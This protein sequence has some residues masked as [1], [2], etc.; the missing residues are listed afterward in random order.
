MRYLC[1]CALRCCQGE[2]LAKFLFIALF[3]FQDDRVSRS[4]IPTS[5]GLATVHSLI[6][7]VLTLLSQEANPET[8]EAQS[9]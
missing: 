3:T 8:K 2:L 7:H 1:Y 4:G 6:T 5:G 9:P